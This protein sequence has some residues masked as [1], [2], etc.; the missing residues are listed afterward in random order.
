MS[1]CQENELD[2]GDKELMAMIGTGEGEW[3]DYPTREDGKGNL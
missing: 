1:G 3:V 2:A